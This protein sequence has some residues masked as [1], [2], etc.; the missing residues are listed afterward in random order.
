MRRDAVGA[1][2]DK[3][4]E[5]LAELNPR[6]RARL[7]AELDHAAHLGDL[8]EQRPVGL[9]D[10]GPAG[11][12]HGVRPFEHEYAPK[13]VGQEGHR[14]RDHSQRLDKRPPERRHRFGVV[15]PEPAP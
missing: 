4:P 13:V 6:L 3:A 8:V 14:R 2:D 9:C 1:L 5:R 15:V 12:V 11:E 10:L 7:T